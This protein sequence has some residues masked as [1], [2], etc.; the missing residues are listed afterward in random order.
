MRSKPLLYNTRLSFT[1]FALILSGMYGRVLHRLPDVVSQQIECRRTCEKPTIFYTSD[2]PQKLKNI[3]KKA[4]QKFFCRNI[5]IFIKI[6]LVKYNEFIIIL[7]KL[8][9]SFLFQFI[10]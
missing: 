7:G 6:F 5:P 4:T 2:A 9:N 8:I 1:F 3:F 10:V